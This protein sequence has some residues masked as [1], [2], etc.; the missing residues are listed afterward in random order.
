V[1]VTRRED[2]AIV[3][4]VW[5]EF[6][7]GTAGEDKRISFS[8]N[9]SGKYRRAKIYRLDAT[10]GSILRAYAAMGKP[11][12]PTQIQ[13]QA[14]RNASNLLP[15]KEARIEGGKFTIILPPQGLALI[16]LH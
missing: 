10:H 13:I 5:N 6:L 15:P 16:E 11:T 7:P 12:Y 14:L 2:G 4:A 9:G 8:I 1:L 3:M